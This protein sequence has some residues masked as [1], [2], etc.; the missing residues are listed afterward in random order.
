MFDRTM[1]VFNPLR[2]QLNCLGWKFKNIKILKPAEWSSYWFCVNVTLIVTLSL[3]EEINLEGL[4][5]S[6][7]P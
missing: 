1:I 6:L 5:L 3:L 2:D 4:S 7:L